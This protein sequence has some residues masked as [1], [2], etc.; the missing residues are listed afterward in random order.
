MKIKFYRV[1]PG[2]NITAIVRGIFSKKERIKI[3]KAILKSDRKIEQ[4]GFWIGP[5]KKK[6]EVRLEMMGGEF[7]GNGTRSLAYVVW[8][9]NKLPKNFLI[10]SS[11]LKKEI[12][13]T[14]KPRFSKIEIPVNSFS[15]PYKNKFIVDMPGICHLITN[16]EVVSK[17]QAQKILKDNHL[18]GKEAA[19]V[20]SVRNAKIK[21]TINPFVWV[22]DTKTL[23]E[24]TACASGTLAL[25]YL[26][27][28]NG[29]GKILKIFQPSGT[30]FIVKIKNRNISLE[31]PIK[32]MSVKDVVV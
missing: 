19:G 1:D 14:V 10:E 31:G 16:T 27:Y 26:K 18:L 13:V 21:T 5:K 23:Y 24:E 6:A 4:V 11:G 20:I 17:D 7:C 30:I 25:A 29:E 32:N 12:K 28:R 15:T 8:K 9:E 22:R 3:S 2:G